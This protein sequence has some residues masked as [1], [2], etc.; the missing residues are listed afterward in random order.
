[1]KIAIL[2]RN[3][4]LYSTKR[5]VEAAQ[6]RGHEVVVLDHLKCDLV[7]EAGQPA[8]IYKGVKLTNINAIIPRIGASVT[9]YGTAV[10]RQFEMMKVKSA[11]NSQ[12][13]VRSRDKLRSMQI[14]SR[15][16]LG[17]PKTAFTNYSKDVNQLIAQVGGAP[18]VIK[19]LEGTQG[20]GVVLAETDKA[21][22]SVIEAFHNLKARIIVQ[23][24]IAESKGADIRAFVVNGE[25]V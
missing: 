14:L 2:S 21:A 11:V 22:E 1:M 6:Q 7:I 20:L 16:G 10:V 12:A 19:L 8:I 25:V 4:K 9:F 5:L 13:I 18:L 24:F 17:M 15:A 23:E 3:S